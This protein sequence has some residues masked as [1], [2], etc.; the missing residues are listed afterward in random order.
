MTGK[1]SEIG[2]CDCCNAE[3]I[4]VKEYKLHLTYKSTDVVDKNLCKICAGSTIY[5][6]IEYD[7]HFVDESAILKAIGFVG[8]AVIKEIRG[9]YEY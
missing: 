1:K 6:T 4:E 3:D 5:K 9:N 2:T 8:N 7:G